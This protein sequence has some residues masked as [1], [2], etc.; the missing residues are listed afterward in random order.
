MRA[1]ST[2]AGKIAAEDLLRQAS[3]LG[4]PWERILSEE[5]RAERTLQLSLSD[6]NEDWPL[7]PAFWILP[8]SLLDSWRVR[9]RIH[10]LAWRASRDGCD[11]A[12]SQLRAL[13][14]HL[15]GKGNGRG[16]DGSLMAK[17]L[18]FGYQRV[19]VLLRISRA[20]EKVCRDRPDPVECLS[21]ETGCSA[22][23]ARWAL[24]RARSSWRGHCLDDAMHRARDE[25][26]ELPADRNEVRAFR[27]L[28]RFIS[29]SRQP[30]NGKA[31]LELSAPGSG[32]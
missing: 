27:R 18:W 2:D 16:S 29:S 6:V 11:T 1:V 15:L 25:G 30:W 14:A 31:E 19:R 4:I 20:A 23:D 13:H 5:I 17:H 21:E 32:S 26:F 28:R 10:R 24:D 7:W 9:D 22:A 3:A 12:A 8:L